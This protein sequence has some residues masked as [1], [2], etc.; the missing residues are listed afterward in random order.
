M[1]TPGGGGMEKTGV[2]NKIHRMIFSI[3]CASSLF[4]YNIQKAA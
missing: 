1:R 4:I 2:K 3:R